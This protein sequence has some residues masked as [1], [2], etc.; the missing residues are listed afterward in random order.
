MCA[1]YSKEQISSAFENKIKSGSSKT[2]YG[3]YSYSSEA[4]SQ[5][6]KQAA[7]N[8]VNDGGKPD[9]KTLSILL[10]A[11]YSVEDIKSMFSEKGINS[12]EVIKSVNSSLG[13]L[14]CGLHDQGKSAAVIARLLLS[15]NAGDGNNVSVVAENLARSG[16][17]RG[18][19]LN[20]LAPYAKSKTDILK[21]ITVV[22]NEWKGKTAATLAQGFYDKGHSLEQVAAILLEARVNTGSAYKA[23]KGVKEKDG[24]V[25]ERSAGEITNVLISGGYQKSNAYLAATNDLK[26]QGI[27]AA[28][29]IVKELVG[30]I[31]TNVS[32]SFFVVFGN[33][34]KEKKIQEETDKKMPCAQLVAVCMVNLGY[35]TE[36]VKNAFIS[37]GF[38]SESAVTIINYAAANAQPIK[39]T[40]TQKE[41]LKINVQAGVI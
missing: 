8:I 17:S 7:A 15:G 16:V 39:D 28:K 27:T 37:N 2:Y 11:E 22:Q 35:S 21:G 4:I 40:R 18:E 25:A 29:D 12:T 3:Q 36:E 19:I 38:T 31:D 41:I 20:G 24:T 32:S 23:L 5:I 33:R 26:S 10:G 14:T 9:V 1:G 34:N 6:L 30:E 13:E